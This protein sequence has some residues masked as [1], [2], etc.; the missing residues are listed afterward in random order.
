MEKVIN[1]F[2]MGLYSEENLDKELSMGEE[3]INGQ[4]EKYMMGN[5]KMG[6]KLV[7]EC[8]QIYKVRVTWV[9]GKTIKLK[10]LEFLL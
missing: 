10:V 7:A 9:N 8:G 3:Y 6:I 5:G 1:I 2:L 4:M